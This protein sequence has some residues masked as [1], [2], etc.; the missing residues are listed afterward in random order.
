MSE[1]STFEESTLKK[2]GVRMDKGREG[3]R[4]D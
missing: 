3:D 4:I 1:K 2:D